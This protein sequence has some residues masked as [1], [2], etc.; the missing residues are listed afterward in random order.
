MEIPSDLLKIVATYLV[1]PKMKLLD[2][3]PIDKLDWVRLSENPGAI[4]LLE[5]NPIKINWNM[6]S[7]NPGAIHM[8]ENENID[9]FTNLD[10]IYWWSLSRNPNALNLLEA[11]PDKINWRELSFNPSIFE[12]DMKQTKLDITNKAN[13]LDKLL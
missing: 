9:I 13:I 4:Q 6:L 3:I 12:I 8:L 7:G 2:W 11:N 10:Q 1:K 5:A